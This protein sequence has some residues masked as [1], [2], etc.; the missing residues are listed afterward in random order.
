MSIT[1]EIQSN[2]IEEFT[3]L[4]SE[5]AP[6]FNM[7]NTNAMQFQR[8]VLGIEADYSGTLD[9]QEIINREEE[10]VA[11]AIYNDIITNGYSYWQDRTENLLEVARAALA[12]GR[13]IRFC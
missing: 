3:A 10:L 9:P 6:W 1:F 7:S 13:N 4:E 11:N 5:G 2:S 8:V 12:L